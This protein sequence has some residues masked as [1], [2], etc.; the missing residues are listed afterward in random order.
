MSTQVFNASGSGFDNVFEEVLL[1]DGTNTVF[2]ALLEE[3]M[4]GFDGS[5]HDF[6]MMVLEN[7]H[8]T[9]T[10]TTPYFFYIE[11]E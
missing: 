1:S 9:D 7:G 5:S 3:D 10:D 8:G 6:Q 11:L 4:S 2:A